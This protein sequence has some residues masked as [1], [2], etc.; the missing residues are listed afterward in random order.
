MQ[1]GKHVIRMTNLN[2]EGLN[3]GW[4]ALIPVKE[5]P[6]GLD[7]ARPARLATDYLKAMEAKFKLRSP[8]LQK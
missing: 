8:D 1:Q 6:L 2:G 3:L 5:L 4:I 7:P